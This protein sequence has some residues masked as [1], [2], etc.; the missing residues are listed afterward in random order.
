M[1]GILSGLGLLYVNQ[2]VLDK[3]EECSVEGL[4][5]ARR[6]FVDLVIDE[7]TG[8]EA[9][10]RRLKNAFRTLAI[11]YQRQRKFDEAE[12]F[13]EEAYQMACSIGGYFW[14]FW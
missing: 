8:N 9:Y 14:S 5:I 10:D 6:V 2:R 12:R 11:V 1:S 3:A 13:Y 7:E 4:K